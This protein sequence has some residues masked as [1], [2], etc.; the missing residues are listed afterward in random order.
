MKRLFAAIAVMMLVPTM[1]SAGGERFSLSELKAQVPDYWEA[2]YTSKKGRTVA[3]N[4][5]I[6]MP[7][8]DT[9]PIMRVTRNYGNDVLK[10][11]YG[12]DTDAKEWI[13]YNS[14]KLDHYD[15]PYQNLPI[16]GR[17]TTVYYD[18]W[19]KER[20][21]NLEEMFAIN[22]DVSAGEVYQKMDALTKE[23]LGGE[24]AILPTKAMI[25]DVIRDRK[26][27]VAQ[28]G[29]FTNKGQYDLE[30]W[31]SYRGIPLLGDP[32]YAQGSS[33]RFAEDLCID[34]MPSKLYWAS[35][36]AFL[37]RSLAVSEM[38]TLVE[39]APLCGF[40]E[41]QATIEKLIAENKVQGVYSLV[42]GYVCWLD[43]EV[44]YPQ[45]DTD[46]A[47]YEGLRMPFIAMP[48]W[49]LE[50]EYVSMTGQD[51]SEFPEYTEE[52]QNP[53]VRHASMGHRSICINAQTGEAID[54]YDDSKERMYCPEI[55]T[56]E[57]V[58]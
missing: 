9:F 7:E 40:D 25:C 14:I 52:S 6:L 26:D 45:R 41:I 33:D 13:R 51:Y 24:Y 27:E 3:F 47:R 12:V 10:E 43:P 4:V 11:K 1:A 46:Q 30:G 22:Q 58:Q 42:L 16:I 56:W 54:P 55:I 49:V 2:S 15:F 36:D 32:H 20:P 28:C 8:A 34:S 21:I 38:E 31:L 5:P 57:D 17:H 29:A 37:L 35:N 50:G 23:I 19:Q 18:L 48:F 44:N 39:D 53:D